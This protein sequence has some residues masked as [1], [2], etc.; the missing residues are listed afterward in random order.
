MELPTWLKMARQYA[1]RHRQ[2]TGR[3]GFSAET[4]GDRGQLYIY[5]SI[6]V[7]W[8]NGGGVTG[9]SVV[10][11]LDEMKAAGA[12]AVDIYINSPGGDIFEAKAIYAALRRFDGERKVHVDGIA[13]SAASFVAMAG[14]TIV[15]QPAATWMIH[16]VRA[17]AWGATAAEARKLAEVLDLENNTFAETYA[18]RTGQTVKDVLGWM[19]AEAWM[20]AAQAK[21]R[22]FTDEIAEEDSDEGEDL[23][24]ALRDATSTLRALRG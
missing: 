22:G 23:A 14:D 16:E 5:E 15:T 18:K 4:S 1:A 6:G 8:W 7:D 11:A 2:A 19:S 21:E 12:K 9:K 3:S 17:S 20:N 10:Q 13:A 24:A